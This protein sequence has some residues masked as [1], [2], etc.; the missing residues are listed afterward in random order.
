MKT[1]EIQFP[2]WSDDILSHKRT[3]AH[4]LVVLEDEEK[5]FSVGDK[6]LLIAHPNFPRA[7][8]GTLVS[9]DRVPLLDVVDGDIAAMNMATIEEYRGYWDALHPDHPMSESP[10]V[11]RIAW[12]YGW[13]EDP[14]EYALAH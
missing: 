6:L 7:G 3:V 4:L 1:H 11:W 9:V 13:P 10:L 5:H 14:P 8:A 2:R 12:K